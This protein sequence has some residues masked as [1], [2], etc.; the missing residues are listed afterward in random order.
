MENSA[1]EYSA[2][3]ICDLQLVIIKILFTK[4]SYT[5][6]HIVLVHL[7]VPNKST[8]ESFPHFPKFFINP[9]PTLF[10]LVT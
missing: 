4:L 10:L 5:V 7:I 8:V 6:F 2:L 3:F 9:D 1:V